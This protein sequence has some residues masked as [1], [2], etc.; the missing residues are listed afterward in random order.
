[1]ERG[2]G[3][4]LLK[5]EGSVCVPVAAQLRLSMLGRPRPTHP[6]AFLISPHPTNGCEDGDVIHPDKA[7][8]KVI[9]LS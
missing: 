8:A 9:A 4:G 7:E 6:G 3:G 2:G 5:K 1:M